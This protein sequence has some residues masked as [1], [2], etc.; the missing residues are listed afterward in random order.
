M[1]NIFI[2]HFRDTYLARGITLDD[3]QE[4]AIAALFAD[5]DV[6]VS[7]PTGAGKTVIA[8]FAVELA[9]LREKRCIYTAPIKALSNQKYRELALQYG[10]ENVGLLTG[11]QTLNH[12]AQIL[13]VTTE[14]LRNML[15][16]Q[17]SAITDIGYVILDEVHY[18][19]DKSRGPVWEELILQLPYSARLISLSA[20]IANLDEFSAWLNSVRG[21][22]HCVVCTVRPVPLKQFLLSY[23]KLIP[24]FTGKNLLSDVQNLHYI[25]NSDNL[26]PQKS[27]KSNFNS[28]A[29]CNAIARENSVKNTDRHSRQ[30]KRISPMLRKKIALQLHEV[31]LL[32]AIEFIFSR[33]GCDN[34]V[35]DLLDQNISFTTREQRKIIR[36]KLIQLRNSLTVEERKA[37][38]FTLWEKALSRGFAAH[39]AGM[40]PAIKELVEE[41]TA[42]GLLSLIYATGTLSLGINMPVRTVVLEELYKWNG[43][44]FEDLSGI[45]YTQLIG[46]A[47]RRGKDTQGT[48]VILARK[49]TDIAQLKDLCEG[50]IESLNSAFFPAYNTV[51]NLIANYGYAK[52]RL[53]MGT[54]FAQYQLNARLGEIQGKIARISAKIEMKKPFIQTLCQQGDFAEYFELRGKAKRASKATRRKA[55]AEYRRKIAASWREINNSTLYAMALDGKLEY[56][57]VLS[58]NPHR[59]RIINLYGELRWINENQLSAPLRNLADF[60]LPH[61]LS[62]KQQTAREIIAQKIYEKISERI[63][64]AEDIDLTGSW[65]RFTVA[66]TPELLAHPVHHCPDL[67]DHLALA[68][69][70]RAL[71]DSRALLQTQ[72]DSSDE[73]VAKE[74]DAA[75][76]VLGRLGII[77]GIPDINQLNLKKRHDS[78]FFAD[79]SASQRLT[80]DAPIL[81]GIHNEND[82]LFSLSLR[83]KEISELN[84][85]EFAGIC[86][87]FIGDKKISKLP[88]TSFKLRNAWKRIEANYWFLHDLENEYSI[89]LT[90]M[91]N[92]SG[93]ELFTIWAEG[94]TL[95][96]V[97]NIGGV[98]VGDFISSARRLIDLLGQLVRVGDGTWIA[99]RAAA[100]IKLIRRWEWL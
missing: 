8:E 2:S 95:A 47:G 90:T 46:R 14:V 17:D 78:S 62:P 77:Q 74:F 22:T 76:Q 27:E 98:E 63:E 87:G 99:P 11:D 1:S 60:T 53:I 18:L 32:P 66:E 55:K 49:N 24:I 30:K 54:S 59:A 5:K 9:L 28:T 81:R 64:L 48:A 75:A 38:K 25:E 10:E 44:N 56:G 61:G 86:A 34:A 91:P 43:K 65:D 15:F 100:A 3:F 41:F 37:I 35:K 26:K 51:I 67:S 13:V 33:K 50:K 6:L 23:G 29:L 4:E 58:H 92:S 73:S 70:Y 84:T 79:F 97:L 20:T 42:L 88:I 85:A 89:N 36:Q 21:E 83:E 31:N 94:E 72:A 52:S 45:E 68:E 82:L 57:V 39:H 96:K 7:A 80:L 71:L 69:E 93:V 12:D 40:F 19:A 16:A